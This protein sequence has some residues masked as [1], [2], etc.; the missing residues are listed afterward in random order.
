MSVGHPFET[1]V[2]ALDTAAVQ[3][4]Q[5]LSAVPTILEVCCRVTGMGFAAVARVTPDEWTACAVRDLIGFGLELL[6]GRTPY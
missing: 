6:F 2:A 4:V 1:D 3:A 5:G